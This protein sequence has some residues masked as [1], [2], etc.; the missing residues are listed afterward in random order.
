MNEKEGAEL[1]PPS[2]DRQYGK[3]DA[4]VTGSTNANHRSASTPRPTPEGPARDN[5]VAGPRTGTTRSEPS[6]PALAR[7]SGRH[8]EPHPRPASACPAQPPSKAGGANPLGWGKGTR[9][10]ESRPEHRERPDLTRRSAPR[11]ATRHAREAQH[12]PQPRHTD[13]C[14]AATAAGCRKAGERSQHATNHG[15][16]TGVKQHQSPS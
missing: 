8:N 14:Q 11:G 15:R 3:P 5:P 7:A 6:A 2:N 9:R 12:R 1:G 13:R 10:R 16:R 4:S